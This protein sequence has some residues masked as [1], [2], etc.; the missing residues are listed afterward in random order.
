M[1]RGFMSMLSLMKVAPS[2]VHVVAFFAFLA[3]WRALN[4]SEHL[5]G[6]RSSLMY[7]FDPFSLVLRA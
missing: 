3:Y 2:L 7:M 1:T 6:V 4:A 5:G